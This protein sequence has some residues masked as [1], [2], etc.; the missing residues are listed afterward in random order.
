MDYVVGSIAAL[1]SGNVTPN[2]PK[3]LKK[4]QT[5]TKHQPSPNVTPKSEFVEDR[6]IFL[7]PTMI[8]KKDIIKKSPKRIFENPGLDVTN[9]EDN[10]SIVSPK[11]EKVKKMLKDNLEASSSVVDTILVRQQLIKNSEKSPKKANKKRLSN[12][13]ENTDENITPTKK[14]CLSDI[15]NDIKKDISTS[16]S[17][18]NSPKSKVTESKFAAAMNGENSPENIGTVSKKMNKQ[19]QNDFIVEEIP[20]ANASEDLKNKKDNQSPKKKNRKR[21]KSK[22][23]GQNN[24]SGQQGQNNISMVKINPVMVTN[25][26]AVANDVKVVENKEISTNLASVVNQGQKKK[27]KKR[28]KAKQ[29]GQIDKSDSTVNTNPITVTNESAVGNDVNVIENTEISSNLASVVSQSPRKKKKRNKSKQNKNKTQIEKTGIQVTNPI[30]NDESG[31]ENLKVPALD[32]INANTSTSD[33]SPKKK[34]KKNKSKQIQSQKKTESTN[35]NLDSATN[36]EVDSDNEN[37]MENDKVTDTNTSKENQS[38]EDEIKKMTSKQNKDNEQVESA[39]SDNDEVNPN[40]ITNEDTDSE[41]DS[42]DD[43]MDSENEEINKEALDT[44]PADDSSDEETEK[45]EKKPDKKSKKDSTETSVNPDEETKR[46]L[47]V[48]N[49]PFSSKCKK[50]IKKIFNQYGQIESVR[51]RTVPVK[52]ARDTPKLA[53]IKNELHPDR[54]TV[55]VYVRFADADSVNK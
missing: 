4:A 23:K 9:G 39:V 3:H 8:K 37:E 41:H 45:Q 46:T 15:G 6:S 7:S 36:M 53:V 19:P 47:F 10:D 31:S 24:L 12:N 22:Q 1:L 42:D 50:E 27:K 29:N 54:T 30:A 55:N 16:V 17:L 40:A 13:V 11:A 21:N 20:K 51:I 35:L 34:N 14:Q 26:K 28:N 33:S 5:P 44:G 38:Q 49:V 25:E 32:E 48:G 18:G 52:D 2:R 43:E